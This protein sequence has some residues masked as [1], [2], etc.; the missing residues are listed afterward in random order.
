MLSICITTKTANHLKPSE[1]THNQQKPS[2]T[3][4]K[5]LETTLLIGPPRATN[6]TLL[7]SL[8][9]LNHQESRI[10]K[11]CQKSG[12]DHELKDKL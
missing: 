4:Q 11:K 7:F 3:T 9:T 12:N 1:I 2:K 8:L 5:L 6:L 10:K